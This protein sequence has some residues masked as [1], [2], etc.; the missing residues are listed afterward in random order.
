MERQHSEFDRLFEL[1]R[2]MNPSAATEWLSSVEASG[3]LSE[4]RA[5]ADLY[6]EQNKEIH[7]SCLCC[8][9][10]VDCPLDRREEDW[11]LSGGSERF[12][13]R[14]CQLKDG[15]PSE[16]WGAFAFLLTASEHASERAKLSGYKPAIDALWDRHCEEWHER[17]ARRFGCVR[18]HPAR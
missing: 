11:L 10:V 2:E 17:L 14:F 16:V 5:L 18:I 1:F 15:I 4:V 13:S 8:K 9:P 7:E 3:I 12:F 6:G